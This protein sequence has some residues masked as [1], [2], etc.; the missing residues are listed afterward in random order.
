[1]LGLQKAKQAAVAASQAKSQFL[2][3]TSHE[4][5][6]PMNGVLG[7]TEL[8]LGTPLS[9]VQRRFAETVRISGEALFALSGTFK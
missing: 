6:T 9:D 4:I 2:A 8:L 7:R 3:N 5:R 1:V